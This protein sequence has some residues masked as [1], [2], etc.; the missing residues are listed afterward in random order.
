MTKNK[1]IWLWVTFSLGY[2]AAMAQPAAYTALTA[3]ELR[4]KQIFL[5]GKSDSKTP[6]VAVLSGMEVPASTLPCGSCHGVQG[7]GNVEGGVQ[8]SDIRWET[9]SRNY[10]ESNKVG[11]QHPPYDIKTLKKAITMGIDPGGNSL[12]AMMPRYNMSATD[13]TDLIAYIKRLGTDQ[14]EGLT[15]E[16][17]KIA[18][19][20]PPG[21]MEDGLVKA[22]ADL[23]RAR[24]DQVNNS[25]GI[26]GRSVACVFY[27]ETPGSMTAIEML[28][29]ERPFVLGCSFWPDNN[30]AL[31]D[32]LQREKIPVCAAIS[33]TTRLAGMPK[34]DVFFLLPGL[35]DQLEA[36]LEKAKAYGPIA[37]VCPDTAADRKL[38]ESLK[39]GYTGAEPLEGIFV[40][41]E[42]SL[43]ELAQTVS[44]KKNDVVLFWGG[45]ELADLLRGFDKQGFF[46]RVFAPGTRAGKQ[47]FSAPASFNKR[48]TLAYPTW[49]DQVT[50]QGYQH[51]REIQHQY[52]LGRNAQNIQMICLAATDLL[53]EKL[54][55]CGQELSREKLTSVLENGETLKTGLLPD[56]SFHPN[57]RVGSTEVFLVELDVESKRLI[58]ADY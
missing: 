38:Y 44:A 48:V 32:Y 56:L 57:K 4:G 46:P 16:Q 24:F 29:K 15:R 42:E 26:Y 55:S 33:E 25:G 21:G 27:S 45:A 30:Q 36:L 22:S 12:S 5:D 10:Q 35:E 51:F 39:A 47:I 43:D 13:L 18:C 14:D 6:V 17:I 8:P 20:L 34:P 41:A 49:I 50:D 1:K 28:Q 31:L 54:K 19:L 2:C 23:I 7:K 9:L 11:R 40:S 53:I 3:E 37:L 58:R 52:G